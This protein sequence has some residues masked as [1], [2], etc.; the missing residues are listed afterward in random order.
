MREEKTLNINWDFVLKISVL[1]IFLYFLFLIQ[2]L[3][4]WFIFALILSI[5]FN[6]LIDFFEKK[7]VPRLIATFFVYSALLAIISFFFYK[8]VPIFLSDIKSFSS[9]LPLYFQKVS[10]F[11]EKIGI[12]VFQGADSLVTFLENNL[13]KAGENVLNALVTIFGGVTA[14]LFIVFLSFF[15]SLEKNLLGGVLSSFAPAR[16]QNYVFNLLPRIRRKVSGWF[17]SRVAGML[18]VGLLTYLVL[19]ILNVKY[20]FVL[21]LIAGVLDF[22]PIIGPIIGAIMITLIVMMDSFTQALF[23]LVAFVIIQQLENNLLFPLLFKKFIGVPPALV[24]IAL[25]IGAQLWGVL[26]AIL[27]VPLAGIIFELIKDYLKIKRKES[28]AEIL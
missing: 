21:S 12:T 26:G 10:P 13:A 6:F 5:L 18:F 24:L 16:Y 23:V 7:K 4:V 22:I 19:I 2:N 1:V 20:A 28:K 27:A 11:L 14:T 15:F 17:I 9:N 8:T 25:A 3:V